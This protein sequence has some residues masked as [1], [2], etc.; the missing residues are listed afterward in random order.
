MESVRRAATAPA[1]PS[2]QDFKV[3]AAA[4]R[5]MTEAQRD[6]DAAKL[7]QM[8]GTATDG[9]RWNRGRTT[10][11]AATRSR[12]R[13]PKRHRP[14]PSLPAMQAYQSAAGACPIGESAGRNKR[15]KALR[16]WRTFR[17]YA[18]PPAP[19]PCP[20]LDFPT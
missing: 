12:R 3:A 11:A 5:M 16:T 17:C 20:S 7:D 13:R 14:P 2:P 9:R 15:L 19:S 8:Q 4:Q 10:K 6:L 1:E 18:T